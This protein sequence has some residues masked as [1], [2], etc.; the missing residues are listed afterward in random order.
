MEGHFF[1]LCSKKALRLL[2]ELS[3]KSRKS[4]VLQGI[5]IASKSSLIS[6]Q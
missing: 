1:V 6:W 4:E 5:P 3:M 2:D